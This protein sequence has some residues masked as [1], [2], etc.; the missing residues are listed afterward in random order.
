MTKLV[1]ERTVTNELTGEIT[2][3][4]KHIMSVNSLEKEPPY[5]KMYINDIGLWQGLSAGET[6]IL[7]Q[8]SSAVDYDGIVSLSKY[9]KDKIKKILGVSDG[10]I[11]N[12]LTKLVAKHILL[13]TEAYS[14]VYKLN[15]YWFG[16][17]DWKDIIEQRKAF[18][19]QITKAYGMELPPDAVNGI[20]FVD[21]H[22]KIT[23][24]QI[25]LNFNNEIKDSD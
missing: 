24:K 14:G 9:H 11:R 18:V 19:V 23:D 17:G 3:H 22:K 16:K 10:F 13:K 1:H 12:T 2:H 20:S 8:V 25:Q 6:S 5:V 15:P 21:T 7:Y 4:E